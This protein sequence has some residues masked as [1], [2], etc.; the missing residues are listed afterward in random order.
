MFYF[1]DQADDK[2]GNDLSSDFTQSDRPKFPDPFSSG[3]PH[4]NGNF[5]WIPLD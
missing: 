4:G 3:H 2:S 5:G 1:Q